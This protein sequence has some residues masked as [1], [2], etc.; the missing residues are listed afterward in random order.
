MPVEMRLNVPPSCWQGQRSRTNRR[1]SFRPLASGITL[2]PI[3]YLLSTILSPA[4]RA[5]SFT[6]AVTISETNTTYDGQDIVVNGATVTINGTHRF[7]SLLLT[8]NAVLTH[9]VASD[10]CWCLFQNR[11]PA[12][13]VSAWLWKE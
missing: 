12:L 1:T 5:A 11:A 9:S 13:A 8:N 6:N 7:N 3:L 2:L 4:A 10:G